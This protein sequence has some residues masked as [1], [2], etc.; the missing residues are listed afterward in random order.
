MRKYLT[1]KAGSKGA[2][3]MEGFV[4]WC[5]GLDLDSVELT[6]YFFPKVVTG[7]YLAGLKR[8]CFVHGLD[9]SGGAV[10]N[11]FTLPA[12]PALEKWF[13]H[14]DQW[15]DYYAA[16]G[17]GV[18]RV[19]AGQPPKGVSAEQGIKNA[20]PNLERACE[21]AGKKGVILALE[22]HDF[23]TRVDRLLEIIQG[24]KSK[25]FGVNL[26]SGNFHSDDPYADMEKVAK[27]AVNVQIKVSIRRAGKKHEPADLKKVMGI[28][29]AADYSGPVALEYEAKDDPYTAVPKYLGVLRKLM[30]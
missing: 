3:N 10:R 18:I 29:K 14:V 1:A 22:N 20:I 12:G 2:M 13:K 5:A 26:D 4:D 6:S 28:L 7:E 27:Y 21:A 19:F 25:W 23:V 9:I 16:L 8:R 24:V 30:G 11:N 15:V 17:A